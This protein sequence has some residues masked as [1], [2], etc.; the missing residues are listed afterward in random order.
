MADES[1]R[2]VESAAEGDS[3]AVEALLEKHLP[4]LRAFLRLR[5]GP[6]L[7]AKESAQ[8]LAQSACL[9]V[10]ANLNRYQYQGESNFRHWLFTTALRKLKNKVEF[11][12]AAKRDVR[13]E[14]TPGEDQAGVSQVYQTLLTPSQHLQ[15]REDLEAFE[16]AFDRLS[17][18]HREVVLLARIVGLSHREIAAVMGRTEA[19]TRNLLYRAL[20]ELASSM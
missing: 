15:H 20:A 18:D 6:S 2:L 4:Q 8:D 7:R 14:I 12:Q 17:E 5:M 19:A 11:Y 3:V 13:R 10:L 16:A 9:E 1:R